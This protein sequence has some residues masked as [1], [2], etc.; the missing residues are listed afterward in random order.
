MKTKFFKLTPNNTRN[1]YQ[2]AVP[3]QLIAIHWILSACVQ[4]RA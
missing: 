2:N 3:A 1:K 4:H